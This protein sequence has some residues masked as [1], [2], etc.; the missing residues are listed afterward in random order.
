MG[1]A[2]DHPVDFPHLIVVF[3]ELIFP[4]FM[5]PFC[6]FHFEPFSFHAH[7]STSHYF[8]PFPTNFFS[9]TVIAFI[10]HLLPFFLLRDYVFFFLTTLSIGFG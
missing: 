5:S 9:I 8:T 3:F 7:F 10:Q 1:K 2:L 6:L 4:P